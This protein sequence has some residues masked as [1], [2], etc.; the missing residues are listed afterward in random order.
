MAETQLNEGAVSLAAANWADATGF[1]ND[2]ELAIVD[3]RQSITA[4]LD[5]TGS[6]TT[7]IDYLHVR[8]GFSGRVG[9]AASPASVEFDATYT[10]KEN[11]IYG[12][13]AGSCYLT[14]GAFTITQALIN[15]GGTCYFTGGTITTLIATSGRFEVNQST[16]LVDV[17]VL[18]GS[19]FIDEHSSDT[20]GNVYVVAGTVLIKR[21][22][23]LLTIGGTGR[24]GSHLVTGGWTTVTQDG[25]MLV[26]YKG[27]IATYNGRSGVIDHRPALVPVTLGGTAA[28]LTSALTRYQQANNGSNPTYSNVTNIGGGPTDSDGGGSAPP[29]FGA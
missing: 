29:S 17:W 21:A 13:G 26:P 8:N 5:Q 15:G 19:H 9:S 3:G 10:T 2:A 25:G 14:S 23:T 28:V 4:G 11:F 16:A 6:T 12:A 20:L 18:G 1:A 22:G 7:G 27:D 24:V